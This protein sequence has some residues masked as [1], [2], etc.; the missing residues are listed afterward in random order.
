MKILHKLPISTF[1]LLLLYIHIF[2]I[3]IILSISFHIFKA[4]FIIDFF[5]KKRK[6]KCRTLFETRRKS[7]NICIHFIMFIF[8]IKR[9]LVNRSFILFAACRKKLLFLLI[10]L[11]RGGYNRSNIQYS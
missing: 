3:I 5:V 10:F 11:G 9:F 1:L 8:S 4:A 6:K 7:K 2:L